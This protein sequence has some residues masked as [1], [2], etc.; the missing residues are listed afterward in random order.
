VVGRDRIWPDPNDE[1]DGRGAV[2][3]C[4]TR[5]SLIALAVPGVLLLGVV[6]WCRRT[7]AG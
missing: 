6:L 4:D 5:E 3:E 1:A 7:A 2:G